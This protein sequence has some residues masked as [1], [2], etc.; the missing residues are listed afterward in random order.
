MHDIKYSFIMPY[1]DRHVQLGKTLN[2]FWALYGSRTDYE[3]ILIEDAKNAGNVT[4]HRNFVNTLMHFRTRINVRSMDFPKVGYNP[5]PLINFGVS[6][7]KGTYIVLTNPECYHT[8]DILSGFDKAFAEDSDCYIVCG[9][10]SLTQ[11]G[12]FHMWY[13]H[14][15]YRNNCLHFCTAISRALFNLIGGFP[16]QF[17][18]GY[19]FDDDA[20]RELLISKEIRFVLRDDLLVIHQ[21]HSKIRPAN[22]HTLWKK[23]KQLYETMFNKQVV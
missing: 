2:T 11:H 10:K 1:Y 23:N 4:L 7:A 14:S 16:S 9:C 17:G 13:Q 22:W 18:D 21:H 8:V 19:A 20:F 5:A 6:Y 15:Q 12:T 3:I